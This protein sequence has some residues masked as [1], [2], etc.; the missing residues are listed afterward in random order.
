MFKQIV[1]DMGLSE[2]AVRYAVEKL[3]E[4]D[5]PIAPGTVAEIARCHENTV[6]R[7]FRLWKQQ[8]RLR[9]EGTPRGGYTYHYTPR[10]DGG[11]TP[12]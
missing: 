7:V 12:N 4:L 2:V 8:G 6:R 5:E 9:M 1:L 10:N 11:D 3:I